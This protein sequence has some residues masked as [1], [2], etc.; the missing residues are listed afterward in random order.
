[1][2]G[3]RGGSVQLRLTLALRCYI[4]QTL[5]HLPAVSTLIQS[6]FKHSYILLNDKRRWWQPFSPGMSSLPGWLRGT[7]HRGS[8]A[9][10]TAWRQAS[11]WQMCFKYHYDRQAS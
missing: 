2:V 3:V 1:M 10:L 7:G 11:G 6:K 5:P 8:Q 9:C 4:V